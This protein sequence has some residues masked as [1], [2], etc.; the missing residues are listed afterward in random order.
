MINE[1]VKAL[2][3]LVFVIFNW[4][5]MLFIHCYLTLSSVATTPIRVQN[6]VVNAL[7]LLY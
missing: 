6:V 5:G 3:V 4:S 1:N 2:N 7:F